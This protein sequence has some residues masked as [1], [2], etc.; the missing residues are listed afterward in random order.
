MERLGIV[1]GSGKLPFFVAENAKESGIKEVYSVGFLDQTDPALQKYV[2]EMKWIGLGQL[3][4]LIDFFHEKKVDQA[5][6]IGKIDHKVIFQNLKLDFTMIKLA[7]KIKDW[8]TDSILKAIVDEITDSGVEIIDSTTYLKKNMLRPGVLTKTKP[9]QQQQEDIAFGY[10]I[11]KKLGE[12]DV[13]QTVVIKKKTVLALEAIEGTDE[14]I[15]RGGKLGKKDAVV[16]KVSKPN[17]DLRF[18]VPVVGMKTMETMKE[19]CC[20]LLAIE[21]GKTL[22]VDLDELVNY[23]DKH[24]ISIAVFDPADF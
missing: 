6:F 2:D 1:A 11:A 9:D 4:K 18:D 22:V 5:V 19:A 24:K 20:S 7:A 21:A 16:V 3:G 10:R 15:L 13:G 14:A 17:Q 12:L 23:A 8:R